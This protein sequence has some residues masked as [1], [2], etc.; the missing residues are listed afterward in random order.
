MKTLSEYF[1]TSS[2]YWG[3]CSHWLVAI[4]KTRDSE[5]L[6]RSNFRAMLESLGGNG[7]EGAKGSHSI[8]DDVAI[9]EANHWACGWIQY[10]IINPNN[11]DLVAIATKQLE[12]LENY[13]V[14]DEEDFSRE[15][16]EEADLVWKSCY[17]VK[18]RIAYIREHRS[19]FDFH[20]LSD[21]LGC[22]RGNYFAGY[23]SELLH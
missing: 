19:Q 16:T 15:E 12:R 13:P 21:L 1:K 14:L 22:V 2:A 10:L 4:I 23:A 3:E 18:E 9:E 6:E 20:S 17:R 11:K 5:A 7:T 8:S